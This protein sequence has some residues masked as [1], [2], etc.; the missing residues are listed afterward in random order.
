MAM[1]A[2]RLPGDLLPI[3]DMLKETFHYPDHPEWSFRDDETQ[4]TLRMIRSVHRLWPLLR[5]F[6]LLSPP[7][8]DVFRGFV[9][10]EDGRIGAA[11]ILAREG[12]TPSWGVG[13]VGVLPEYRRRGLARRLLERSLEYLR[14]RKADKTT[15][16]VID[17][18]VPAY[19]LYT[20][21]GFEH[22]SGMAE[23]ELTPADVPPVP[24][25]PPGYASEPVKLGKSWRVLYDLD[26]RI[27]PGELEKYE[28]VEI[29]RYRAPLLMRA[30]L[31]IMR[32]MRRRDQKVLVLR[33]VRSGKIVAI[34]MTTIPKREGGVCNLR[35]RL[36]PAHGD[37]ADYLVSSQL[38]YFAVDGGG[39]RVDFMVPRWM[40]ALA[41]SAER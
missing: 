32:L 39:R 4:E 1:R 26:K 15:L 17:R 23:Y 18:N 14:E 9:W 38:K 12:G 20:S 16:G 34:A 28:P 27:T 30:F 13:M 8:R 22:Y 19:S 25:F 31:P 10:E 2:L 33:E 21:L 6:S 36:D 35:I 24:A 41:A 40:P 37:L 5:F 7:L 3:G 11:V 29:G